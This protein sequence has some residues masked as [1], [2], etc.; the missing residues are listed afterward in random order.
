MAS[1]QKSFAPADPSVEEE[2]EAVEEPINVE[3]SEVDPD[4]KYDPDREAWEEEI[5]ERRL[6]HEYE[7]PDPVWGEYDDSDP[8]DQ[9][10][11]ED[12]EEEEVVDEVD[13]EAPED[14]WNVD[15]WE[16]S[17]T[18]RMQSVNFV[19]PQ[20]P[21]E[22][23]PLETVHESP[24]ESD[25]QEDDLEDKSPL[26][27]PKGNPMADIKVPDDVE[28]HIFTIF[29]EKKGDYPDLL[30]HLHK[31][32]CQFFN[33]D[34]EEEEGEL[35]CRIIEPLG[36]VNYETQYNIELIETAGYDHELNRPVAVIIYKWLATLY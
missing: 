14:K 27:K 7:E 33:H 1:E 29:K 36:R 26:K 35:A 19:N 15:P 3:V 11:Q 4:E 22:K 31:F 5:N 28:N 12:P 8:W 9:Y 13:D 16:E 18:P 6:R 24:H 10:D 25:D 21:R 32:V 20:Q 30:E 34:F 17:L 23:R 2:T